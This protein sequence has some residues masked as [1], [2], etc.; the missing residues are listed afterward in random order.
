MRSDVCALV[1]RTSLRRLHQVQRLLSGPANAPDISPALPPPHKL[2]CFYNLEHCC[3]KIM[4]TIEH[5]GHIAFGEFGA[6]QGI[7]E[8][9]VVYVISDAALSLKDCFLLV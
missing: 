1:R 9:F 7:D 3:T 8:Q 2:S 6:H 5:F 4:E